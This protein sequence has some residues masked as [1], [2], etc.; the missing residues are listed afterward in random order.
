M[1]DS[2]LLSYDKIRDL[3]LKDNCKD[4]KVSVGIWAKNHGYIRVVKQINK[5][6]YSYYMSVKDIELED[7]AFKTIN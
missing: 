7:E 2:N 4:N 1:E 5:V 3:A 6:K